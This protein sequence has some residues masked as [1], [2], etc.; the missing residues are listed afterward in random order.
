MVARLGLRT[1]RPLPSLSANNKDWHRMAQRSTS[2]CCGCF[3]Q[4]FLCT[5]PWSKQVCDPASCDL[6]RHVQIRFLVQVECFTGMS[7]SNGQDW[8]FGNDFVILRNAPVAFFASLDF[9]MLF[10]APACLV[11]KKYEKMFGCRNHSWICIGGLPCMAQPACKW[12]LGHST[13]PPRTKR[14]ER[15]T[16][17]FILMPFG[18]PQVM[19]CQVPT[20]SPHIPNNVVSGFQWF[21]VSF[22]YVWFLTQRCTQCAT[23]YV[24]ILR[25]FKTHRTQNL[26]EH[27]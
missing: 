21:P 24:W 2:W 23:W 17:H 14:L 9:D 6:T 26:A 8:L 11:R 4:S 25:V 19:L 3:S 20:G 16:Q 7:I 1:G 27:I 22:L 10:S 13:K 15:N 18:G 12:D 5:L